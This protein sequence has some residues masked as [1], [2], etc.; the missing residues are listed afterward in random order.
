MKTY[1]RRDLTPR[2][3]LKI[4]DIQEAEV[5]I[6]RL[7]NDGV[8]LFQLIY[9]ATSTNFQT[10]SYLWNHRTS[11]L[12]QQL[13]TTMLG[14]GGLAFGSGHDAMMHFIQKGD[15]FMRVVLS[16]SSIKYFHNH[17]FNP[18]TGKKVY[19]RAFNEAIDKGNVEVLDFICKLN[20]FELDVE[21]LEISLGYNHLDVAS[22]LHDHGC[23]FSIEEA[24]D[25]M[26]KAVGN[27]SLG[28]V[29]WLHE[30]Y[31]GVT[32]SDESFEKCGFMLAS[33]HGQVFV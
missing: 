15:N 4:D 7:G 31:P 24:L 21:L 12:S 2:T 8:H 28:A 33:R 20:L 27:W 25:E 1:W 19:R 32:C 5:M 9:A 29:K 17:N 11:Y 10:F 6:Q 3:V 30:R 26:D 14:N 16:Y 18:K 23:R 22:Y 13:D